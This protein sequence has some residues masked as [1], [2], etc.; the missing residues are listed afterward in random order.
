MTFALYICYILAVIFSLLMVIS[1]SPMNSVI[2]LILIF[3]CVALI[4]ML[5]GID[6]LGTLLIIIY[7]GAVAVF[8][9]FVVMLVDLRRIGVRRGEL[10]AG[11]LIILLLFLLQMVLCF[12]YSSIT[13]E[14]LHISSSS[15]SYLHAVSLDDVSRRQLMVSVGVQLF[16]Y[17]PTLLLMAGLLLFAAL[18]GSIYLTNFRKG[19]KERRQ[20]N[21]LSRRKHLYCA[22]LF[23]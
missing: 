12:E 14:N 8:F 2:C 15:Y 9:L 7:V 18:V 3:Y 22:Y 23:D 17:Y 1:S 13:P 21:Q 10:S 16:A 5:I 19:Y 4:Y 20:Y 11:S 6:F